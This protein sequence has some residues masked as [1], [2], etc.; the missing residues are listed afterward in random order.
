[1]LVDSKPQ[2]RIPTNEIIFHELDAVLA[3]EAQQLQDPEEKQ[4]RLHPPD[5]A[6]ANVQFATKLGRAVD[7]VI[8]KGLFS[9][10][11][12]DIS[13]RPD[14]LKRK[15][16]ER[17]KLMRAGNKLKYTKGNV[18]SDIGSVVTE[19]PYERQRHPLTA[20]LINESWNL[21]NNQ[22]FIKYVQGLKP[23]DVVLR[24]KQEVEKV[25]R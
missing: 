12:G 18:Y 6:I 15:M 7:S 14:D 11:L 10:N 2:E 19:Y 22:D 21:G 8:G 1:M 13:S 4:R 3:D 23:E 24:V 16:V 20:S 5:G 17:L 25:K 9:V